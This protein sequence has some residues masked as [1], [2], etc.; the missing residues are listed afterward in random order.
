MDAPS[1]PE[2]DA[3]ISASMVCWDLFSFQNVATNPVGC[4]GLAADLVHCFFF[5][6]QKM[7]PAKALRVFMIVCISMVDVS[8]FVWEMEFKHARQLSW[9][10]WAYNIS[11]HVAEVAGVPVPMVP[12]IQ[13]TSGQV[14]SWFH[15]GASSIVRQPWPFVIL[16]SP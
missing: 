6:L 3:D 11:G 16:S 15:G 2:D 12:A 13:V 5:H 7:G 9:F 14:M 8:M 10:S 1:D 4:N